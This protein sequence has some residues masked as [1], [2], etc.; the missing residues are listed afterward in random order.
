MKNLLMAFGILCIAGCSDD[1]AGRGTGSEGESFVYGMVIDSLTQA[2]LESSTVILASSTW[3][4][5]VYADSAGAFNILPPDT[6]KYFLL[7]HWR[8]SLHTQLGGIQFTGESLNLGTL[9]L[10]RYQHLAGKITGQPACSPWQVKMSGTQSATVTDSLGNFSMD[11]VL[12]GRGELTA[13]CGDFW[14]TWFI[15][16]SGQCGDAKLGSLDWTNSGTTGTKGNAPSPGQSS[17]IVVN[18]DCLVITGS[19]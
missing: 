6:G 9:G 16:L 19:N 8:D 5:T 15:T 13:S 2:R 4:D 3:A 11:Q 7:V 14:K 10:F 1:V 17:H 18:A 12:P